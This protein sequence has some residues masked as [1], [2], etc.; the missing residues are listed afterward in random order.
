MFAYYA[1]CA[2]FDQRLTICATGILVIHYSIV[3]HERMFARL[4]NNCRV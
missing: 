3:S 4:Q 2:C 1:L